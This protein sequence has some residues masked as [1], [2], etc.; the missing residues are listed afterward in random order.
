MSSLL[1]P[2]SSKVHQAPPVMFDVQAKINL[3]TNNV[4]HGAFFK[5]TP[6]LVKAPIPIY[7]IPWGKKP[8]FVSQ[9]TI[10][11]DCGVGACMGEGELAAQTNQHSLECSVS[12]HGLWA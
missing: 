9:V 2:T 1:G 4:T 6:F 10:I 12:I 8:L 5:E 7:G 11:E 3:V